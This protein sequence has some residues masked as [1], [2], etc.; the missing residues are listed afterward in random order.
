MQVVLRYGRTGLPLDLPDDWKVDVIAG[1]PMIPLADPLSALLHALD[2]GA[3]IDEARGC[4]SACV[5]ICDITRPVP[6]SLILPSLVRN[7]LDAGMQ[8]ERIAI[9]V[10]TGLHRPNLGDELAELV[11]DP[12]VLS[13]V[14]VTNHFARNDDDHVRLGE[15]NRGTP[16]GLDRRF[17]EADLRIAVGLVE[18]H[19]MAGYS[20]GWKL[21]APGVAH[22][23]TIVSLH[24]A[25]LLSHP[26]SANCVMDGNPVHEEM[27]EIARM[28]GHSL[29]VNVV[30]DD[31]R[32]PACINFG[33]IEQSHAEAVS[34]ARSSSEVPVA[35]R[36][37][38]VVTSCAGYPLDKTYY[39][40]VKAMV[41]AKD[42]LVP[43]GNLFVASECSEGMGSPEYI[44]AQRRLVHL[45]PEGF[46]AEIGTRESALIDEW[47]SQMQCKAM[48]A[49]KVHLYS[50]G[51]PD[52]DSA[53]TGVSRTMD[54]GAAIR[55][56]VV[57]AGDS[58]IAVIPEG[59][60]VIPV[61]RGENPT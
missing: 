34:F 26:M 4:R 38:T 12:W 8:A 37:G 6:N 29:A 44:E 54:L 35:R 9:L 33:E 13:T 28:V 3:L 52:A 25:G 22:Y 49:G 43:G 60:Y 61:Y 41:A 19:F 51:L 47:Q 23:S 53:L 2:Q 5:L 39:Q 15:T 48:Q 7:L 42:I 20:G 31:E 30:I 50:T 24:R 45:G 11:G 32:R 10:A 21:I 56:S 18:P 59:P 55:E 58:R 46:L 27:M 16:V 57:K 1:K 14:S 40:T 17:V 36:Y